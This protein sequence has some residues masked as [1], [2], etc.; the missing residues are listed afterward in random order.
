MISFY[1]AFLNYRGCKVKVM[2]SVLPH[3]WDSDWK[4]DSINLMHLCKIWNYG[5][6]RGNVQLS[7]LWLHGCQAE[8]STVVCS[9]GVQF[10]NIR[11]SRLPWEASVPVLIWRSFLKALPLA[12][13]TILFLLLN[14]LNIER[15]LCRATEEWNFLD[16]EEILNIWKLLNELYNIIY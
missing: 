5:F 7:S 11:L 1:C 4:L 6:F 8:D 14:Q 9:M 16:N 10:S 13:A 12:Y 2:F 3:S 15:F